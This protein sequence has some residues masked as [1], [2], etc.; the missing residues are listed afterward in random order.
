MI[1]RSVE[2]HI[3]ERGNQQAKAALRKTWSTHYTHHRQWVTIHIK[4]IRD[5]LQGVEFRARHKLIPFP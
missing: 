1:S 3:S 4:G 2:R 5:I